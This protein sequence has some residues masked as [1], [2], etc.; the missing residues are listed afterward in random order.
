M[1]Y[2]LIQSFFYLIN[3]LSSLIN[4]ATSRDQSRANHEDLI[5]YAFYLERFA[6]AK[7]L[8]KL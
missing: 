6:V 3:S 5:E 4:L 7:H 1:I 8:L 2:R